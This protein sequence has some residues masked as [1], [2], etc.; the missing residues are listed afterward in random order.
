M[1]EGIGDDPKNC[2]ITWTASKGNE[3]DLKTV[4]G[5]ETVRSPRYGGVNADHKDC[6]RNMY[7]QVLRIA[8]LIRDG[9][10]CEDYSIPELK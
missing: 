7:V 1:I 10:I 4:E 9:Y 6:K 5:V 8:S 3:E 2:D